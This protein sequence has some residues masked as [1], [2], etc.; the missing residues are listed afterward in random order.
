MGYWNEKHKDVYMLQEQMLYHPF[1]DPVFSELYFE[2]V[3]RM[4][5]ESYVRST[6]DAVAEESIRCSE[7]L[8]LEFPSSDF[9]GQYFIEGAEF[10]RNYHPIID[11]VI[12]NKAWPVFNYKPW[13]SVGD[14][15]LRP[16]PFAKQDVLAYQHEIGEQN[17]IR[18]LCFRA[19]TVEVVGY[20]SSKKSD[21]INRFQEQV[22]LP[23]FENEDPL[24]P[25][26][27]QVPTAAKYIWYKVPQTDDVYRAKIIR[28]K[29]PY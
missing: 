28:W 17:T 15:L 2:N 27:V 25:I 26:D 21:G 13:A 11:S 23:R 10:M 4:S 3:R 19:S 18:L 7:M 6:F 20:S 8:Q 9:G 29:S 1:N 22:T 24:V 14:S 5:A 16:E 12:E